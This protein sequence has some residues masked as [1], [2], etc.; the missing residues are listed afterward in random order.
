MGDEAVEEEG[1]RSAAVHERG[2]QLVRLLLRVLEESGDV[3]AAGDA[4]GEERGQLRLAAGCALL[5]LARVQSLRVD[6]LLGPLGWHQLA[7]CMQDEEVEVRAAIAR[8]VHAEQMRSFKQDKREVRRPGG[9][10]PGGV[11]CGGK[12][13]G[14]V[15][16]GAMACDGVRWATMECGGVRWDALGGAYARVVS[17]NPATHFGKRGKYPPS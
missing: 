13:S 17:S 14:G 10:L 3:G 9:P 6:V 12:V 8:K 1:E 7:Y 4:G 16:W 5:K 11:G 15:R 2:K